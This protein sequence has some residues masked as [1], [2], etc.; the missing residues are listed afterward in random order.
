MPRHAID[1]LW[2]VD[3]DVNLFPWMQT[4]YQNMMQAQIFILWCKCSCKDADAK[5]Y[6]LMQNALSRK[7]TCKFPWCKCPL[8]GCRCK[9]HSW[10]C[11][12]LIAEMQMRFS[13]FFNI[14]CPLWVCHDA[15]APLWECH[16]ANASLRVCHDENAFYLTQMQF[17]QKFLLFSKSRLPRSLEPLD[18]FFLKIILFY[19]DEAWMPSTS[20]LP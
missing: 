6:F 3:L 20:F 18:L 12:C 17:N 8:P 4:F 10:W 5:L 19:S 1:K 15:N 16:D 13:I 11:K 14:K 2:T 7:C 9:V